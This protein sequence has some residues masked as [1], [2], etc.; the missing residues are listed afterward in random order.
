MT[1]LVLGHF[2]SFISYDDIK[3]GT[4]MLDSESH[5][6]DTQFFPAVIIIIICIPLQV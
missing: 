4:R 5:H 6:L 3:S 2:E 1:E